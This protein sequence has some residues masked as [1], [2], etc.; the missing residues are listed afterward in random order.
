M[1]KIEFLFDGNFDVEGQP[2]HYEKGEVVDVPKADAE[3]LVNDKCAKFYVK[4]KVKHER[5][6]SQ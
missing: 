1:K 5:K 4:E 3:R 6:N 2:R